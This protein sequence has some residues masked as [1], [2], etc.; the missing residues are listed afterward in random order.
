MKKSVAYFLEE[1]IFGMPFDL[2]ELLVELLFL[3]VV[4]LEVYLVL[5]LPFF[6]FF[7][8]EEEFT[9]AGLRITLF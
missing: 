5:T 8:L 4:S 3:F 1:I 6:E 2:L 9:L 7:V